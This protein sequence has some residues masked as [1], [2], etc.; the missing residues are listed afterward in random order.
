[1][2]ALIL[3][4]YEDRKEA[5]ELVREICQA[6][7]VYDLEHPRL[8]LELG[9]GS[10]AE[11]IAESY[12]QMLVRIAGLLEKLFEMDEGIWNELTSNLDLAYQACGNSTEALVLNP[13][14]YFAVRPSDPKPDAIYFVKSGGEI[15]VFVD[16]QE[17]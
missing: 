1:M 17:V 4:Y 5:V 3:K 10:S 6:L 13:G 14:G 8:L 15:K 2:P 12:R 11:L 7:M 16:G 9:Y